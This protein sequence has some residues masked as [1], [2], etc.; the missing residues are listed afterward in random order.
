M[1]NIRTIARPYAKA[2]FAAMIDTDAS[3]AKSL[4]PLL[5][6]LSI[7][8]KE[9]DVDQA[10]KNP[11]ISNDVVVD[12]LVATCEEADGDHVNQFGKERLQHWL[13]YLGQAKR[14]NCLPQIADLY[15]A[16]LAN[17]Q[18]ALDVVI[19]STTPCQKHSKKHWSTN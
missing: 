7:A 11:S 16:E 14:L 12:C 19:S 3:K 9:H 10:I 4:V 5:T 17:Q 2:M 15:K 18:D 1:S 13:G 6:I 8:V